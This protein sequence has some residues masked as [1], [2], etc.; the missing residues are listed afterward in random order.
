MSRITVRVVKQWAGVAGMALF[1]LWITILVGASLLAPLWE[2][3]ASPAGST[4][5]GGSE[6][7]AGCT[8]MP[9]GL[10]ICDETTRSG[11]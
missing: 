8:R 2:D 4:T 10:L 11:T 1:F 7:R 9:D 3:N 6:V 5:G